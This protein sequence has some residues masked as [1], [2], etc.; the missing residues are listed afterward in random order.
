MRHFMFMVLAMALVAC[1]GPQG[2]N[3]ATGATGV[4]GPQG[5]QGPQG[6][7]YTPPPPTP[8][9]AI[10]DQENAYRD[11]VGQEPLTPGL[12]CTLYTVPNTTT[13]ISGATLTNIGSFEYLGVFNQPNAPVTSGFNVLPIQIQPVYQTWFILKCT[14]QFVVAND[15]WHEWDLTSD[16]GSLLSIGGSLINND[17]LHAAVT[18]SAVKFLKHGLYSFELDFFQGAGVQQLNLNMDGSILTSDHFYH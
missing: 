10:V 1:A 15:S 8:I 6:P 2:D 4:Q 12:D 16:D 17:G 9:Q 13:Q 7:A 3:G 11:A 18:K 14:G 5:I